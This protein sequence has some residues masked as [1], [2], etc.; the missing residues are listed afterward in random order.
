MSSLPYIPL[1]QSVSSKSLVLRIVD[2]CQSLIR[3]GL[4]SSQTQLAWHTKLYTVK[5]EYNSAF[6]RPVI[7]PMIW[8]FV[9]R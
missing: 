4:A 5:I 1:A 7:A 9:D 6:G 3:P 2:L 8:F